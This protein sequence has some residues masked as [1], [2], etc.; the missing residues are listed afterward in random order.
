[1][2]RRVKCA[3]GPAI[4]A[5]RVVM[6]NYGVWRK[7]LVTPLIERWRTGKA[8][9]GGVR[10]IRQNWRAATFSKLPCP[11]AMIFV[12]MGDQNMADLARTEGC[13]E[14][15]NMLH[16][17]RSRIYHGGVA[18]II[19]TVN[20]IGAAT[21]ISVRAGVSGDHPCDARAQLV[22]HAIAEMHVLHE[23]DVR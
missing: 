11:A 1:M 9:R 21:C 8:G 19:R 16:Q 17:I 5:N 18:V 22:G 14:C 23:R 2:S 15:I 4:A 10:T 12:G 20:D 3:K 13:H 7:P 6:G